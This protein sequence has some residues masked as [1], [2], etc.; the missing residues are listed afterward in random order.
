MVL[1]GMRRGLFRVI[2]LRLCALPNGIDGFSITTLRMCAV[3][4]YAV[5]GAVGAGKL[6]CE[7]GA[8]FGTIGQN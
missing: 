6:E 8:E 4:V 2:R 7:N 3:V 5:P 1:L